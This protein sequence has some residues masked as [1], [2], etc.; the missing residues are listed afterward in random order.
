MEGNIVSKKVITHIF[1]DD[2][3][4]GFFPSIKYRYELDGEIYISTQFTLLP[5]YSVMRKKDEAT[6]LMHKV[7]KTKQITVYVNP[8]NHHES[9]I[10]KEEYHDRFIL[11]FWGFIVFPLF[12]IPLY[13]Y[14]TSGL[15]NG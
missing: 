5:R 12:G 9:Y 8:N 3:M 15:S 6:R 7:G 2:R 4:S 10:H 1:I 13:F 11:L 14:L